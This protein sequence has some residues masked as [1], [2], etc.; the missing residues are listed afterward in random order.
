MKREIV[1]EVGLELTEKHWKEVALL[2]AQDIW[3][4]AKN[5]HVIRLTYAG[6]VEGKIALS[7]EHD[8]YKLASYEEML[9]LFDEETL[10]G[11]V[12]RAQKPQIERIIEG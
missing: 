2:D 7:H 1:E 6:K 3:V 11:K 9:K 4:S 12:L 5:L 8:E 10:I